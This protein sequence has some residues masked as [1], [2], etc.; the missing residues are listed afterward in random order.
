MLIFLSPTSFR[1][2]TLIGYSANCWILPI[3]K[4]NNST[5]IPFYFTHTL[6]ISLYKLLSNLHALCVDNNMCKRNALILV[7]V[8][9]VKTL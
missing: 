1:Y 8:I 5:P 4:Y 2:C 6:D 9:Q 7:N 3:F